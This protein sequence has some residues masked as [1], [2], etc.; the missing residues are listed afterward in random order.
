MNKITSHISYFTLGT[1]VLGFL[2]RL[3]VYLD[4]NDEKGLLKTGHLGNTLCFILTAAVLVMLFLA[5]RPL[6]PIRSY[7]RL[8]PAS[9]PA[10]AGCW[11]AACGILVTAVFEFLDKRDAITVATLVLGLLSA[12]SLV[13]LGIRRRSGQRP[14]FLLRSALTVYL[15]LHLVAQYRLWSAQPQLHLYFFPL[16]CSVFLMLTAYHGTILDAQKG[17]RRWFVFCSQA[18]LFF[19]CMSLTGDS[20]LFYL[21]MGI[22]CFTNLCSLQFRPYQPKFAKEE[23]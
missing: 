8:Y 2:L 21:V 23:L 11:A 15:M 13:L 10:A 18:A 14:H 19:C 5:V 6:K 3:W 12:V 22:F 16:L 17:S 9:L 7:P 4:G 20:W 1:G